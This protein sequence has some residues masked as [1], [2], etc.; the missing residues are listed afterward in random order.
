M[1]QEAVQ[2]TRALLARLRAEFEELYGE[3][4]VK[5]LL[6]GSRARGDAAVDSDT[7]V[8][9]V[10]TGPVRPMEEIERTGETVANISLEFNEVI[11]CVFVDQS[12]FASRNTPL[13]RNVRKEGVP[14]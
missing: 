5:M 8:L 6:Y 4:L 9:V 7:D 3:R 13:L 12:D 11:S 1:K 10:L 14:V 2:S